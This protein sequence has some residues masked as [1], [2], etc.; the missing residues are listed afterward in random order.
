[1]VYGV[2]DRLLRAAVY[3]ACDHRDRWIAVGRPWPIP[4][5]YLNT[6]AEI[7]NVHRLAPLVEY[8]AELGAAR[9]FDM[10]AEAAFEARR[11]ERAAEEWM[12]A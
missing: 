9:R 10:L 4:Q 3:Q 11:W 1:M 7:V 12:A 2:T 8:Q 5:S 6:I